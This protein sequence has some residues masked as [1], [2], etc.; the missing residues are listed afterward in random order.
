MHEKQ[1]NGGEKKLQKISL[2]Q[3]AIKLFLSLKL[4][5]CDNCCV[6]VVQYVSAAS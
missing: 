4:Y 5:K 2:L 3:K 6:L 1:N